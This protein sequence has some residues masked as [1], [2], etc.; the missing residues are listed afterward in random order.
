M[1]RQVEIG[2]GQYRWNVVGCAWA[3]QVSKCRALF[4]GQ[5]DILS[6]QPVRVL[7]LLIRG[8]LLDHD[9]KNVGQVLIQSPGLVFV[10]QRAVELRDAVLSRSDSASSRSNLGRV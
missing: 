9:T 3:L 1:V 8:P 10:Q 7:S 4:I 2:E 6:H 5:E